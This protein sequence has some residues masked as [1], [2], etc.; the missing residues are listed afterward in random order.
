MKEILIASIS[1][2]SAI[3]I[4]LITLFQNRKVG[5]IGTVKEEILSEVQKNRS[6]FEQEIKNH[7]LEN[8]KTYLTDFLSDIE[9]GEPKSE[10]QRRRASEIKDEYK[11]LGGDSYVEEK[12]N[13][14]VKRRYL[15]EGRF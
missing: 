4:A 1:P 13:E 10:I 5:K 2:L 7:I 3:I 12:W 14:L 11:K 8:D 6:G 15:E 9:A